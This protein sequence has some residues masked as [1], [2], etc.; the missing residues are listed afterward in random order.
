MRLLAISLLTAS[1]LADPFDDGQWVWVED[2]SRMDGGHW[3]V[4]G[5]DWYPEDFD[6]LEYIWR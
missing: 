2:L 6:H 3:R 5:Y 4:D 1:L